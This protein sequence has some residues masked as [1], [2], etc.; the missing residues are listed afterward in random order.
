[1]WILKLDL[2]LTNRAHDHSAI[3]AAQDAVKSLVITLK[4]SWM[5]NDY[6]LIFMLQKIAPMKSKSKETNFK[7]HNSWN[8][9]A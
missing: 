2:P 4:G 8:F 7:I 5:K 1:M 3:R 9:N 6:F